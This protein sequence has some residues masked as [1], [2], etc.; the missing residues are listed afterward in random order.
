VSSVHKSAD[1]DINKLPVPFSRYFWR[2]KSEIWAGAFLDYWRYR[3]MRSRLE[4]MKKV[5]RVLRALLRRSR[6]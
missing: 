4:P 1:K 6:L 5:A 2:Y 3:V